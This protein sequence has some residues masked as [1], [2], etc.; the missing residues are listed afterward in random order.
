MRRFPLDA[1]FE[2]KMFLQKK[3]FL[4]KLG[5][6]GLIGCLLMTSMFSGVSQTLATDTPSFAAP[7]YTNA[8]TQPDGITA[9]DFNGDGKTDVATTN[10]GSGTI[11]VLISDGAGAFATA[12]S[13]A[14]ETSP[15]GITTAYLNGDAHL[16]LIVAN[17]GSGSISV[18]L[19]VGNGTFGAATNYSTGIGTSPGFMATGDWDGDGFVDLAVALT[20]GVV[21]FLGNGDGTFDA[22]V[23]AATFGA[24]AVGVVGEDFNGDGNIDLMINAGDATVVMEGSGTSIYSD[25][26]SPFHDPVSL[27]A[28]IASKYLMDAADINGDSKKDLVVG[29]YNGTP[30]STIA[31]F[32]NT[33]SGG[34]FSFASPV[35][36]S[37]PASSNPTHAR[38][39][40]LNG[41][42]FLDIAATLFAGDGVSVFMGVGDGTFGARTDFSLA[43]G[44]TPISLAYGYF[45]ANT[46]PDLVGSNFGT[47]KV[48]LLLNLL[49]PGPIRWDGGGDGTTWQSAGNWTTDTVPTASD[50]VTIT[51]DVSVTGNGTLNF[52]TLT[53]GGAST[54]TLT[55]TG[56]IG[57]GTNVTIDST[58]TL[59]QSSS[60]T[61]TL[62]GAL[63]VKSGGVLTHT[64]NT[65]AHDYS[66]NF[67]AASV[68]VQSG[69]SVN[70][71][72]KG[73]SGFTGSGT[74]A[75][76]NGPSGGRS[77]Y[78]ASGGAHGGDGG[79]AWMF[80][81]TTEVIGGTGYC[82]PTD[83]LTMGSAGGPYLNQN[84][85]VGKGGGL[86]RLTASG[87]ITINGSITAK[88]GVGEVG[89]Y[90]PAG[91]GAGGGIN[92][93]ANV[94]S[95][96]TPVLSV[97]GGVPA[98]TATGAGGGGCV[99]MQYTD[100]SAVTS[101]NVSAIGGIGA[102]LTNRGGTGIVYFQHAS[103]APSVFV[104]GSG[105]S[106]ASTTQSGN[107]FNVASITIDGNAQYV[108]S[109]GKALTLSS[110]N[111]LLGSSSGTISIFGTLTPSATTT[112]GNVTISV[113]S[114]GTLGTQSTLNIADT[115]TLILRNGALL[116][117]PV[118]TLNSS[119][120]L[121]IYYG[122]TSGLDAAVGLNI[123]QS[124]T[125]LYNFSTSTAL[126]L[127]SL[128]IGGTGTLTHAANTSTT[129]SV[130]NI[131]AGSMMIDLGGSVVVSSRGFYSA[132]DGN[133]Q[134]YG[135]GGGYDRSGGGHGGAGGSAGGAGGVAYCDALSAVETMGSSGG[136][137]Y[138][139]DGWS[140]GGGLAMFTVS[141]R[142]TINGSVF[143]NG[144]NGY[145]TGWWGENGAG[146][147]GGVNIRTNQ[148]AGNPTSFSVVGGNGTGNGA[149]GGGGCARIVYDTDE[150]F[151]TSA[152]SV[153]G[154]TGGA[155]S[156]GA[157]AYVFTLS[158]SAPTASSYI[159]PTQSSLSAVTVTSTI[160]DADSNAT[161][162]GVQYSTNNSDWVNATIATAS[163]NSEGNGVTTSSGRISG[164]DTDN[165]G[166]I[167]L[168]FAWDAATD[169]P[170]TEDSSV[171]LRITPNDG[172]A[173]GTARTSAAFN[174]DT[175]S[176]VAP[177]DLSI[178]TTSTQSVTFTFGSA[179]TDDNF[180]EYAIYYKLGASGVA[181]SDSS[182]TSS[183]DADLGAIDFNSTATTQLSG[184]ATSTQY[185]A[186]I[187]AY[188]DIGHLTP[189][190]S[191]IAFYTLADAP[192]TPTVTASS[193][194]TILHLTIDKASNPN[195]SA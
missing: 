51:G 113:E 64:A 14:V 33:S 153:A 8:E 91:S 154:G 15:I 89:G 7:S 25:N 96:T 171:Y 149:S 100:T 186:N 54:G 170:N 92:I 115:A 72:E 19:G 193:S 119:G 191:E 97:D 192:G 38:F 157:G 10:F 160:A 35:E 143:A 87:T 76:G 155:N 57:T 11:S 174:L 99:K 62:S 61:Q 168:T 110:A 161:I 173:S 137:Y 139:R 117:T 133:S 28:T 24:G 27:D 74:D 156:G 195:T 29:R 22:K 46:S 122:G 163:E 3:V 142:T 86:V 88:G 98:G 90:G 80:G 4:K 101:S 78:A 188:D 131:S 6:I 172:T 189:A 130:I 175:K 2:V 65:T 185:V 129:A 85:V 158:N 169:L 53:I 69:G 152:V 84:Y 134:A 150:G 34:G 67:S 128:Y 52:S 105:G 59:I 45:D 102:G 36:Y 73:Y 48:S 12:V 31:V 81:P 182:F 83:V 183:T 47:G 66:V 116:F 95:G 121:D 178:N 9:A 166:S 132:I 159:G 1:F 94:I 75:R 144:Q 20:T 5:F 37:V 141:G 187:W 56:S 58:G 135:P 107:N 30:V 114:D 82:D 145:N 71:D 39:V 179:A 26:G 49:P 32:I 176:P 60:S 162:L 111:P 42:G 79:S 180:K 181:V 108:I 50:A 18:L 125:T 167:D 41:D 23:L 68:D 194:A 77:H 177:G 43:V 40:D 136:N 106:M 164:I 126:S 124:T 44:S 63:T 148:I 112:L 123:G 190:A 184:L 103:D 118:T 55:L 146:A 138:G 93:T 151:N 165:D 16:D 127:G 104:V 140:A 120:T 70:V 17:Y 21:T 147:G 13:Y 109:S